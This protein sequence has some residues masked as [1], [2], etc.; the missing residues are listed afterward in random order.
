MFRDRQEA[1]RLL[2]ERLRDLKGKPDVVILG[3][4]RGGVLVAAEF[5]RALGAPLDVYITRKL[6]A[7]GNPELAIG[8]VAEDG[9]LV[10]DQETIA[11]LN[12]SEAYLEKERRRQQEEIRRR[13]ERYRGGKPLLALDGKRVVLVDDGVATGR[14]LEAAVRA[15]R[16][17]P[18]KELILA[19]PVGPPSTVERLRALVDRL[20]VLETPEAFW[21]VGMFYEDFHQVSD[22]EVEAHLQALRAGSEE[23][24]GS[25]D[26]E[27]PLP[28]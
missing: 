5:A 25:P 1:G 27:N 9:T 15:L 7:P 6:G 10:I 19:I 20:E 11:M 3:V 17:R 24:E 4:P 23:A 28:G 2:A 16:R 13:A 22:A 18:L 14:T 21:A 12:V 8:A 26:E